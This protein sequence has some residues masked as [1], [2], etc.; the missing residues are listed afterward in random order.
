[1]QNN[2][3]A[4]ELFGRDH[5]PRLCPSSEDDQPSCKNYKSNTSPSIH[6]FKGCL[7]ELPFCVFDQSSKA[8]A[9]NANITT[10]A[11]Y[12]ARTVPNGGEFLDA[13][14]PEKLEFV[15][16]EEPP[17]SEEYASD[18]KIRRWD[19][20]LRSYKAKKTKREEASKTA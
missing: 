8:D 18:V 10:L 15:P 9:F 5:H 2:N 16:L 12:I 17:E 19:I 3:K 14:D 11:E 1:M 13:L 7:S 4:P 20:L 6:K